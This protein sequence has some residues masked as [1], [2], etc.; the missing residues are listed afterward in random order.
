MFW[1][2]T[3]ICVCFSTPIET[4]PTH[5]FWTLLQYLLLTKIVDHVFFLGCYGVWPI[6]ST[7]WP[8]KK[9]QVWVHVR[10]LALTSWTMIRILL[11]IFRISPRTLGKQIVVSHSEFTVQRCSSGTVATWPAL[12]KKQ[13]TIC[14]EVNFSQTTFVG[15]GSGS[16]THT[17][18]SWLF[19][20]STHSYVAIL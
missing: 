17:V 5:G 8:V 7:F 3:I 1:Y 18:E 4:P 16:K 20:A 2:I 11:F 13:S 14:F 15:F 10:E 19:R 12:P 6:N 9:A